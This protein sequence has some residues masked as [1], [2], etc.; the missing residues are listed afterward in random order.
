M[1]KHSISY[2]VDIKI[3]GKING[4]FYLAPK[5]S[6]KLVFLRHGIR[7]IVLPGAPETLTNDPTLL[8]FIAA[9]QDLTLYGNYYA[10][11]LGQLLA[12]YGTPDLIY[13]DVSDTRNVDTAVAIAKGIK[14]KTISFVSASSDPFFNVPSNTTSETI[15]I[16]QKLLKQFTPS[17]NKI[18]RKSEKLLPKLTLLDTT[19]LDNEGNLSGLLPQLYVLSELALFA[20]LS[21][22]KFKLTRELNCISKAY[23]YVQQLEYPVPSVSATSAQTLLAGISYFLVQNKFS[24]LVGHEYNIN[25]IAQSLGKI[26]QV[27]DYVPRYVQAT[28]GFIFTLK[29]KYLKIE[30]LWLSLDGNYYTAKYLKIPIPAPAFTQTLTPFRVG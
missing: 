16:S 10:Y 15:A 23:N 4:D 5:M 12:H 2:I 29:A 14:A 11:R 3:I 17:I 30:Y 21:A 25:A 9:S 13:P 22:V 8:P 6:R 1:F 27:G 7:G 28:S 19:T 18:K 26:Y 20:Q 24:I